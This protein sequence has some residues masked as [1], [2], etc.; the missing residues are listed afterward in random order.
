MK[1]GQ[2]NNVR[3]SVYLQRS[4]TFLAK[5]GNK[6]RTI[7]TAGRNQFLVKIVSASLSTRTLLTFAR[8]DETLTMGHEGAGMTEKIHPS[9]EGKGFQIGDAIGWNYFIDCCFECEGC[10][11]PNAWCELGTTRTQGLQADGYFADY[12]VV[13]HHNAIILPKELDIKRVSPLFCA[14]IT[15]FHAV[16]SCE[17]QPGQWIA[18]IGCGGLGQYAMQYAKAMGHKVVGIDI[19]DDVLATVTKLGADAVFNSLKNKD[20]EVKQI[21]GKG[22]HAAAVFSASNI[23]Y[24]N[25]LQVLRVGGLLMVIGIAREELNFSTFDLC[26]GKYRFKS[27]STS[28]PQRMPKAVEFTA[29]HNIQPDVDFRKLEELPAMGQE[30]RDGKS[31]RRQVVLFE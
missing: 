28:I 31:S 17:L 27:E 9:A 12:A 25:A 14:G 18:V 15:T 8:P 16:D 1:A 4:E 30:M 21:T 13:N 29:K 20:S 2:W 10:Q 6:R 11:V 24:A 26:T 23:A 3:A 7:P 19:K 5:G 22:V